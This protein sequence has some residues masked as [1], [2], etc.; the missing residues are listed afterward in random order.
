M[1]Q[2]LAPQRDSFG[3]TAAKRESEADAAAARPPD[4]ITDGESA[5][6]HIVIEQLSITKGTRVHSYSQFS[7]TWKH[8]DRAALHE[9]FSRSLAMPA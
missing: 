6:V 4:H 9:S 3:M 1:K 2:Q 7:S 5:H 8:T